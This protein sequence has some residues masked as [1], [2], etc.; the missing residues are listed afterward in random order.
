M[1][2]SRSD[3][4]TV[5]ELARQV[6]EVA[7]LPVQREKRAMWTRLNR[8][9]PVRPMVWI[10]EI[11]WDELQCE[12]L[13][14]RC[15]DGFCRGI[16][17]ELRRTLYL[18]RH[19][20][21]DM[22]VGGVW[23]SPCAYAD[24]GFGVETVS[25]LGRPEEGYGFG[26][27]GYTPVIRTDADVERIRF[28]V[29]TA[30]R[31]ATERNFQMAC[32]LLGG[33]MPVEKRG[34]VHIW[35]APW[36]VLVQWWGV[37]EL[38]VDMMDRPAFVHEGIS[39][40][41]EAM[42]SRLDQLEQQGLLSVSDG[43]HR[44][45][46]GGL[47]IT[48]ELPQP[49]YDGVH[50]RPIDQWG[51]ATG[52]IFSEVSPEMHWEF[53]LQHELRWLERFGLNC[54]GCC[55]PLHNKVEILRRIPRLRRISMSRWVNVEKGAE[56]LGSDF[57]FS[58]KPNPAVLAW[59]RWEPEAARAELRRVLDR[60]RGCVVELIMKDI[61]TCRNDPRRLWDWCELA[62]RVVQEYA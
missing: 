27:R 41:V 53:C 56:E 50:A 46:S 9:E 33:V 38:M 26:S 44:V 31:G 59:D 1:A 40:M 52:Q 21:C 7:S 35:F 49:D 11:P 6:M 14:C 24:S 48:D 17:R 12:E 42:C 54:Y 60:T 8:L 57:I 18:W 45:G 51:T 55:E 10:N 5:R 32:D 34:V 4:R 22:V 36:D 61:S 62:M 29:V 58:Y 19:M 37:A 23:Y 15:E 25:A 16:E 30:D 20:R 2:F 47:G 39:R 3:R 28:P 13:A 43:N